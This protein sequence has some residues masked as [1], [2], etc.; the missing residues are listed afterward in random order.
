MENPVVK[1]LAKVYNKSP[2]QIL[3]RHILQRGLGAIPKS[4]N[5]KRLQENFELFDFKIDE[6]GMKKLDKLDLGPE[7]K[8]GNWEP[9]TW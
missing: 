8:V 5:P 9:W 1:E 3:L 2:A 7:G 4:S 6:T